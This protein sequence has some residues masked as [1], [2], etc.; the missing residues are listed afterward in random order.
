MK[1]KFPTVRNFFSTYL[2]QD[3]DLIFGTA[4]DAMRKFVEL[5][6]RD[7][8]SMAAGEIQAIIDMKLSEEDLRKLIFDDLGSYYY[9]PLDW[10]SG[11]LWLGHVLRILTE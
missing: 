7:K 4:D 6:D 1:D 11:D 3:F 2:N 9:Y 8:V 5:S 10:L